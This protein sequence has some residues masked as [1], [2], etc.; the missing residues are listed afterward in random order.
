MDVTCSWH[1]TATSHANLPPPHTPTCT[2]G[3]K[4]E[5]GVSSGFLGKGDKTFGVGTIEQLGCAARRTND[6][7]D[8]GW[9]KTVNCKLL[10]VNLPPALRRRMRQPVPPVEQP[11]VSSFVEKG[12]FGLPSARSPRGP[13]PAHNV[14]VANEK[15]TESVIIVSE[16][17]YFASQL[18]RL[19]VTTKSYS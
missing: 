6:D 8:E 5:E 19:K 7:G 2:N 18:F 10:T 4:T 16:T 17:V 1:D 13:M 14:D 3:Y 9:D 12:R 15:A 11:A